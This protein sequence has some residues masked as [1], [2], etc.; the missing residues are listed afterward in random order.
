MR[1]GT[2]AARPG[3]ARRRAGHRRRRR[4]RGGAGR[5]RARRRTTWC[6]S[7]ST[8]AR[9]T[10]STTTNARAL[11][12]RRSST[13]PARLLRPGGV[14][15]VWSADD[16]ARAAERDGERCSATAEAHAARRAAAGPR[17]AVLALR[18][19]GT[20]RPHERR[21]LPHRARQHGRGPGARDALWR[22]QT[23]RA[24]ENFPI[25]GTALEPRTDP[26]ARPGQGRR[27]RGQRPSSASLDRGAGRRRSPPPPARSSPATTTTQ[28]PIDVFQTGSGTSSNMNAN[29]VIAI[30]RRPGR[31]RRPPQRPRQRQPVEQRHLPDLDPRRRRARGHRRP[32]ARARRARGR[33]GGARPRSSPA[34]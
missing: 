10:W 32:A 12:A 9:A 8:T 27:G 25:S 16:G 7:T 31:R 24:V 6:C 21:R 28:F 22:A 29:E 30:A 5:G 17:R 20:V 1:D 34:W 19:A 15:V 11:P 26:R 3:A 33:A 23:Q 2:I 14:L 4:H 18:R 13:R